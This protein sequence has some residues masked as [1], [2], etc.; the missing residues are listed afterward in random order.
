M[1]DL[2]QSQI[3]ESCKLALPEGLKDLMSDISREVLRAQPQNLYHFIANYLESLLEVREALAIACNICSETCE[4][5]CE[6]GLR[7]EL[8][9]VGLDEEDLDKAVKIIQEHLRSGSVNEPSLF[10]KLAKK[11]SIDE[12]CIP[13]I[14]EA[15]QR[16]FKRQCLGNV[17]TKYSQN[18]NFDEATS[19]V[20][21]TK[22]VY[23][24]KTEVKVADLYLILACVNVSS[25]ISTGT[26]ESTP[27][28][29]ASCD[30]YYQ[31]NRDPFQK[32]STENSFNDESKN[33]DDENSN[34]EISDEQNTE[35]VSDDDNDHDIS[36][37]DEVI[38][39]DRCENNEEIIVK[40]SE[41]D[42][43]VSFINE[44]LL[45]SDDSI[46]ERL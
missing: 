27:E 43:I 6:S 17:K 36:D 2:L 45:N 29:E 46:D 26:Y 40:E 20:Q 25:R 10:I 8:M 4:C 15:V 14:Q 1:N 18:D 34:S 24:R 3:H 33:I 11:I 39:T 38:H 28:F 37:N 44:H 21:H 35:Y 23:E 9:A 31:P 22:Q 12:I 7:N 13:S 32:T 5:T 41:N 19:A 30:F 42:S 16:A